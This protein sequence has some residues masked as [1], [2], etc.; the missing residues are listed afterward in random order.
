MAR[1]PEGHALIVLYCCCCFA[2]AAARLASPASSSAS[3]P[4]LSS[5]PAGKKRVLMLISDTGGGHRASAN[6]IDQMMQELADDNEADTEVRIVDIWTECASWP[7]N[8]M[9]A[10]YPW[11]CRHPWAWRSMYFASKLLE[12]PWSI[13]TRLRCGARFRKCIQ[14]FDPDLVVSLHPLCQHLPLTILKRQQRE[15]GRRVPFAVV[16]TDLGGAHPAWFHDKVDACFVPSDAVRSVALKRGVD[17]KKIRQHGLPVRADFWRASSSKRK[18]ADERFDELGLV[19]KRK[20]VLV[21]GGGDG[22]GS[23]GAI[24]EATAEKLASVCPGEA[25]VVALCGKNARVRQEL[26]AKKAEGV[27]DGVEVQTRGFTSEISAYMEVADCLVTKAG[28]GTIAEAAT[29]A[30]P[31][32]LSSFLP[33]QEAGNV[34]YVLEKGFGEY[35][36]KPDRIA[37]RVA[38]WLQDD[39]TLREMRRNARAAATPQATRLIALDLLHLLE[40]PPKN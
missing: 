16:C 2:G 32:M 12:V 34:P 13:E 10:G 14:D 17:E 24:V 1:R 28:P 25:Q 18:P 35:A 36:N 27:F 4:P 6:A 23:L 29:R 39:T 5:R 37:S 30:L 19:P 31:T 26:E 38:D 21:V 3:S 7:H 33:G 20:T 40:H 11:L 15:G 9:A 8:K 22:V